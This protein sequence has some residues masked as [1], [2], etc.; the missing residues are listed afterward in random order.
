MVP[1]GKSMLE[2]TVL[3]Y[4][5]LKISTAAVSL[6]KTWPG[7]VASGVFYDICNGRT[8]INCFARI[9]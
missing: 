8:S 4:A 9:L 6:L 2:G 5:D 3:L 7:A 1:R